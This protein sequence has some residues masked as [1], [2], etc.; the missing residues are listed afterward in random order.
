MG[1][2]FSNGHIWSFAISQTTK[3]DCLRIRI[4]PNCKL[5]PNIPIVAAGSLLGVA[6]SRS[7]LQQDDAQRVSWPVG[8]VDYLD[9]HPM[10]FREFVEAL[11]EPQLAK[12]LEKNSL[13][14]ASALGEKYE[15]LLKLYLYIGGMPEAVTA[16]LQGRGRPCCSPSRRAGRYTFVARM[17]IDLRG[18]QLRARMCGE[19]IHI[20]LSSVWRRPVATPRGRAFAAVAYRSSTRAVDFAYAVERASKKS[21]FTMLALLYCETQAMSAGSSANS[22]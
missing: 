21:V 12:L 22:G 9:T 13:D 11:G 3:Y 7:S 2:N 5:R 15:D 14:L 17:C 8:K 6:M 19:R 18:V 10:T 20:R 1:N 16:W 4:Q